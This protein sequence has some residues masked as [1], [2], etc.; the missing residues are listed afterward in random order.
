MWHKI[1]VRSSSMGL[2]GSSDFSLEDALVER[3]VE[4]I[5]TSHDED[6]L[7][8]KRGCDGMLFLGAL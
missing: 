7:W 1:L 6:C 4:L 2:R 3:Y 8:R 5:I